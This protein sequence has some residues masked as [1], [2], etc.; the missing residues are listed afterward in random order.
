MSEKRE[1]GSAPTAM[2]ALVVVCAAVFVTA[3]DQTVVVTALQP[4][5]NDLDISTEHIDQAAWIVSGYLLGYV[6]VM[7]LMGRVS[8]MYG[9][10]RIFLLCLSIF[11]LASLVCALANPVILVDSFGASLAFYHQFAHAQDQFALWLSHLGLHPCAADNADPQTCVP[12]GLVWL[13]PARFIQ[14]IGGGAIVPVAMAVAGD[15]FGI[16]RRGLVLGVIGAVTEAGGALG[17]LYGAT[18][19]QL[20]G[21]WAWIFLLNVPLVVILLVAGWFLVPKGGH[22]QARIDWLGALL[23][24]A[25][26]TCLS[27]GLSQNAGQT[28]YSLT[29]TAEN[30][31]VLLGAALLLLA[32]FVMREVF[33]R[34]AMVEIAL[35]RQRA[36]SAS[37]VSSLLVG[38]ALIIALVD[39]PIFY[40]TV[41]NGTIFQTGLSLLCMTI[42][43]PLSAV[44]GGWLCQRIGCH[45]TAVLALALGGLGFL[46]MHFWPVN[47]GWLQLIG[48]TFLVGVGFGLVVAPLGTSTL[49]AAG[50]ERGGVASA[51]VTAAR[52][53]GMILGLAALTSWGLARFKQLSAAYTFQQLNAPGV[54][55][56]VLHQVYTEIFLGAAILCLLAIIP[57]AL[58]WRRDERSR[59]PVLAHPAAGTAMAQKRGEQPIELEGPVD[60]N[61]QSDLLSGGS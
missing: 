30:N 53:I 7:P 26:L 11:G 46:L 39:I 5:M 43:I 60:A 15:Y 22:V 47:L 61:T 1:S 9:R 38:A 44:A 59:S 18:I 55:N 8:D 50:A 54:L 57:A 41:V 34:S 28:G 36:F 17:P 52:M 40:L 25:S 33:A 32:L 49:N 48:D 4:I 21:G 37:I 23:L 14:A 20:F 42:W 29:A 27:L 3:L 13:V 10:R 56:N 45:L 31:P 58:L 12:S 24:G 6:I 35:F 2:L 16:G 19:I 51:V